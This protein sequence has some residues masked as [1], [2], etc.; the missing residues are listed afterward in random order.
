MDDSTREH[1]WF[2]E[3]ASKTCHKGH[4]I[5]DIEESCP[6]VTGFTVLSFPAKYL[7]TLLDLHRDQMADLQTQSHQ[8]LPQHLNLGLYK[9]KEAK[10]YIYLCL[11]AS[12]NSRIMQ[13]WRLEL[14]K[15]HQKKFIVKLKAKRVG[16]FFYN[17]YIYM[18]CFKSPMAKFLLSHLHRHIIH[19][20]I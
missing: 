3:T 9:I 6:L 5:R 1:L 13:T 18:Y 2:K 19:R 8:P 14:I 4:F 20:H 16:Q 12:I 7:L 15:T 10:M 11:V 17:I